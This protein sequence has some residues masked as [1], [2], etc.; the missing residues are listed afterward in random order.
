MFKNLKFIKPVA[1]NNSDHDSDLDD[2]N[3]KLN[4][5]ITTQLVKSSANK[6]I[7]THHGPSRLA[8]SSFAVRDVTNID[9]NHTPP[10]AAIL[11]PTARSASPSAPSQAGSNFPS[12]VSNSVGSADSPSNSRHSLSRSDNEPGSII[13]GDSSSPHLHRSLPYSNSQILQAPSLNPPS[14]NSSH[15]S[16]THADMIN[17]LAAKLLKAK[18]RKDSKLIDELQHQIDQLKQTISEAKIAVAENPSN[19]NIS[20]SSTLHAQSAAALSGTKHHADASAN[21]TNNDSSKRQK[22]RVILVDDRISANSAYKFSKYQV[23]Q[24]ENGPTAR[25]KFNLTDLVT[26]EK[27]SARSGADEFAAMSA[28]NILRNSSYKFSLDTEDQFDSVEGNKEFQHKFGKLTATEQAKRVKQSQLLTANNQSKALSGCFYCYNGPSWDQNLLISLGNSLCLA[29]PRVNWLYFGHVIISPLEHMSSVR[30]M[31]EDCL[32]EYN[33]CKDRLFSYYQRLSPPLFPV[34]IECS[35][36]S[37]DQANQSA[38]CIVQCLPLDAEQFAEAKFAFK[39]A[40]QSAD[41]SWKNKEKIIEITPEKQKL[42]Q[43]NNINALAQYIPANFP[44]FCVEFGLNNGGFIHVIESK[45]D[46]PINLGL[47]VICSLCELEAQFL[48]RG[49]KTQA[50][51]QAANNRVKEFVQAGWKGL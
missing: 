32:A 35:Y 20:A 37:G 11:S 34:F 49:K 12:N 39:T 9:S 18:L 43:T 36:H 44:Y 31:S 28:E 21:P 33:S 23:N 40:I 24:P 13:P 47:E 29:I 1:D 22:S 38:H 50:N 42:V 16:P 8:D 51:Q 14:N 7:D 3:N 2:N 27:L 48:L 41:Q 5:S 25:Q 30:E 19:P 6:A 26:E 17:H 46:F 15:N 4:S 45:Q 10:H